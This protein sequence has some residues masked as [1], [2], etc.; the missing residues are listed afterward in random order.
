MIKVANLQ[1]D[2]LILEKMQLKHISNEY[3]SWMNDEEVYRYLET[4]GNYSKSDLESYL[5]AAEENDQ[6]HFWAIKIKANDKHIGNI[7]IDPINF[8]HG[9]GEY[10]IL[11]GDRDEWGKGFAREASK[12]VI[13]YCFDV[14]KLRKVTLGV[15]ADN[16]AAV[17]LYRKLGFVQEGYYKYHGLYNNQLCDTYRMAI[18]NPDFLQSINE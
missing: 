12:G 8:K 6:L 17:H 14:L 1:T 13:D 15:V 3:V 9:Y 5:K 18:F 10:G 11:M 4:G 16:T 7:K 2:R